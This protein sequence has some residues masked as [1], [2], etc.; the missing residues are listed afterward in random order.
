MR[1][2]AGQEFPSAGSVA[3]L[4][5]SPIENDAVLRRMVFVR[6][7]QGYPDFKVRH[8]LRAASWFY[9]N[10]SAE[11]AEALLADFDLPPDRAIKKLSRGMRS[12]LGIVIGLAARAEVTLFDEPYAGLD[13]V[14]RQ[15]F[16]DRLL[17]DYAEH[18]RTVLLS[19]HLIDEAA[20]L[21]ERVVMIDRGRVVLDAAADDVRGSATTVSGP[22][23]AVDGVHRRARRSGTGAG[24]PRRSRWWWSGR[25][26]TPTAPGPGRCTSPGAAVAAA[27]HGPRRRPARD[28]TRWK[29]QAHETLVNV[30]RYHL[31][32][33]VQLPALP[34]AILAFVFV[35]NLV[36]VRQP[37]TG[38]WPHTQVPTGGLAAIFLFFLIVGV[39]SHRPV[40][41]VRARPRREPPLLLPRD[42][43][44]RRHPR[45]R[46]RAGPRRAA[47]HRAGHRRL[48][49]APALL[50]GAVHP[51]PG[52]GTSPG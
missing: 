49:R 20:D 2:L 3:V 17:A 8:A 13:A 27:G 43:A 48:G 21:L 31:V 39:L 25:W 38:R 10:W 15:L 40:A 51:A 22:A 44:A 30:A 24:S 29:G 46:L 1:I 41:A 7:D 12:A 14:A 32:R 36:I 9:P 33:P 50:P 4:G 37:A 23:I 19:T 42:R 34:W 6:E 35:V 28:T 52:R 11:L 47:G 16:Y 45:R 18:P 26:T 5:A